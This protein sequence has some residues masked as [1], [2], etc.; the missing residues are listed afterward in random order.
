MFFVIIFSIVV[1]LVINAFYRILINQDEVLDI[2]DRMKELETESKKHKDNPEKTKEYFSKIMDEN[3]KLTKLS[4]KPMIVSFAIVMV[5]LPL[6]SMFYT[7]FTV[8]LTENQG[9][10]TID[11]LYFVKQQNNTVQLLNGDKELFSCELPC[12]K[13]ID[14][15]Y[16]KLHIEVVENDGKKIEKLKLS[17]IVVLSPV[18]LPFIGKELGWIWLYVMLSIPLTIIIKKLMGVRI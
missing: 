15:K 18:A 3:R 2:K 1:L 4:F 14:E 12:M 13:K 11:N 16:Y 5:M 8:N 7:D 10:V 17:R 6:L 9:N